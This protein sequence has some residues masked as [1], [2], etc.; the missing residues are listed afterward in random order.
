MSSAPIF[1]GTVGTKSVELIFPHD[2][3]DIIGPAG[4]G[5]ENFVSTSTPLA[6]TIDFENA[7][8]ATAPAQDVTI[9]QQ[10]DPN[11]N[12]NTF[13]LTSFGF[14][15]LTYTLSGDNPFY[16]AQLDLT[17]TKGYIVDVSAGV[18]IA[19]GVVT[20]TF[21]TIDPTTGQTPTNPTTGFLPVDDA[22]NDGDAFVSY[23]VQAKSGVQTG[24]VITAQATVVFDNQGP[25]NTA[26]IAD[27]LDADAPSS[28]VQ[29]LPA[30]TNDP[31]FQV[32]WS[33]QDDPNGP[34]IA[35]YTIY[36]SEDGGP[37]T[38]WLTN[39]T[40]TNALFTGA[41]GHTY[42]FSS[43]ATDYAGNAEAEH[44]TPDTTIQVGEVAELSIAAANAVQ[45]QGQSG[46]TAFTFTVTRAGDTSQAQSATWTVTGTGGNPASAANFTGG[47]L[48]A[49]TVS[50]AVG[51]T[52]ETITI[53]VVGDTLVEPDEGFTVTLSAPTNG[54]TIE[55]ATAS[56]TVQDNEVY[57]APNVPITT[58]NFGATR[59]G[60]SAPAQ[61]LAIAD[62]TSPEANQRNLTSI[63]E[64]P[65]GWLLRELGRRWCHRVGCHRYGGVGTGHHH[66][67]RFHWVNRDTRAGVGW[68]RPERR[69]RHRTAE[70][71]HYAGR[72]GLCRR[73]GG[74]RQRSQLRHRPCW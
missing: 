6:Y 46:S 64:W 66:H 28:D 68:H 17:A 21:D 12:W 20:W 38:P 51:D 19:T 45:P 60:D 55:T 59:V 27:T 70:P 62:G 53:D 61:S 40:L 14:D 13:R 34:G 39:T 57:A 9:T 48:P 23:T 67:R 65:A 32:S 29:A 26:A 7:S 47:V 11:L 1:S 50:F 31:T 5:T 44:A 3:N 8:T 52:S 63:C 42:A 69:G 22:N 74:V 24:D 43:T 33:G 10:L 41:L 2:P 49:G 71:G 72:Q 18:N 37:P 15:N 36:V 16:T 73:S 4:F 54:A 58:L 25:I 35:S 30:Q 56:G